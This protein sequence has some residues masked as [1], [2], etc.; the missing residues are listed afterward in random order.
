M[1]LAGREDGDLTLEQHGVR[2]YLDQRSELYLQGS[3]IDYQDGL[4]AAGFRITNPQCQ[5]DLRVR[6]LL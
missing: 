3:V 5:S 4:T 6:D 1:N 2:V